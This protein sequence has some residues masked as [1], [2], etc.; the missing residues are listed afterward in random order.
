MSINPL[1]TEIDWSEVEKFLVENR[2]G[3]IRANMRFSFADNPEKSETVKKFKLSDSS[4]GVLQCLKND[5]HTMYFDFRIQDK[6]G[7]EDR[8]AE[9]SF[10]ES[11]LHTKYFGLSDK[12][13]KRIY[14]EYRIADR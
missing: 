14:S 11:W 6:N 9:Y 7:N 8:N 12:L 4:I 2:Y 10:L 5:L 13:L 3:D 1:P